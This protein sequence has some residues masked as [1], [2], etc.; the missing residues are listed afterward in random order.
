MDIRYVQFSTAQN[1]NKLFDELTPLITIDTLEFLQDYFDID[2]C[3]A[4]GLDNWGRILELPRVITINTA[5]DGV[6][7]FGV[8]DD[9]PI[10]DDG[11]P[12]NLNNG[13]FYNSEYEDNTVQYTMLDYEYRIALKFRYSSLTSNLSMRSINKIMNDLLTQLDPNHKCTV[14][15][16]DIMTLTYK[17][18]FILTPWQKSLF[19]NRSILPV[20]AGVTAILQ[21]GQTI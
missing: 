17:F 2:T 13:F 8:Q 11:Y 14:N 7:G 3:D 9:Y 16:T 12:Q 15:Q 10:P 19:S 6:F 5:T 1:L 18:N 21:D 4:D 20:P